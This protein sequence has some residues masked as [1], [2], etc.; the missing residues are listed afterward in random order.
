MDQIANPDSFFKIFNFENYSEVLKFESLTY[1]DLTNNSNIK[2]IYTFLENQ[3]CKEII[4][5]AHYNDKFYLDDYLH[6]YGS[7]FQ[8]YKRF[9]KRLHFFTASVKNLIIEIIDNYEEDNTEKLNELQNNYL[10]FLIVRP[11]NTIIG[12][13]A[14]TFSS[15]N[16]NIDIGHRSNFAHIFTLKTYNVNLLGIPLVVKSL[17]FQE[18]DQTISACATS[19]LWTILEKTNPRFGYYTPTPYEITQKASEFISISRAIP[20]SGLTGMQVMNSIK[21][22][23][24]EAEF[25]SISEENT[26]GIKIDRNAVLSLCY[27]YL[28]G[29]FPL[30][31]ALKINDSDYHATAILG[32]HLKDVIP[33]NQDFNTIANRIDCFFVHDDIVGPFTR[34]YVKDDLSLYLNKEESHHNYVKVDPLYIVIPVYHKVRYPYSKV[35]SILGKL[36]RM[37]NMIDRDK[38]YSLE[39]DCYLTTVNQYKKSLISPSFIIDEKLKRDLLFKSFPRFFWKC[40]LFINKIVAQIELLVDATEGPNSMPF[41][42]MYPINDNIYWQ[43]IKTFINEAENH[44]L[45]Q[46]LK[47]PRLVQFLQDEINKF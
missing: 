42:K 27:A 12:R 22:F 24:L 16:N 33:P 2:N 19:A 20:S 26:L 43:K 13:T 34:Y 44:T 15:A 40:T 4:I 25:M 31:L 21:K 39:W 14:I 29:G 8:S 5:E 46:Y 35:Y 23:G 41:F 47:S 1:D 37:M 36:M 3:N 38:K 32:Y 6:F 30:F 10:G 45:I 11:L 17:G 28:K 7:C 18:Q 9:C